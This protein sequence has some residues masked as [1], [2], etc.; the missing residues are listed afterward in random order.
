MSSCLPY[1]GRPEVAVPPKPSGGS[2]SPFTKR[3]NVFREDTPLGITIYLS[4]RRIF[5]LFLLFAR[6]LLKSTP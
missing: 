5:S 2:A 1:T 3:L 4:V 6:H